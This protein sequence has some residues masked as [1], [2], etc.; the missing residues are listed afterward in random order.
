MG[1]KLMTWAV[2]LVAV[3]AIGGAAGLQQGVEDS[4]PHW[5]GKTSEAA[6][7]YVQQDPVWT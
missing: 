2:A 7:I 1:K 6:A 5:D 3:I 4:D